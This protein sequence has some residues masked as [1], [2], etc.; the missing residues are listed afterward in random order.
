MMIDYSINKA[1]LSSEEQDT[2]R[3]FDVELQASTVSF[4]QKLREEDMRAVAGILISLK[5][6]TK[7]DGNHI[8]FAF[9]DWMLQ[10]DAWFGKGKGIRWMG[11]EATRKTYRDHLLMLMG[12][13]LVQLQILEHFIHGCCSWLGLKTKN[14]ETLRASDFL[15]TD[16][17]HINKTLGQLK[18]ALEKAGLFDRDFEVRLDEFVKNRNRFVHDYWVQVIK[19]TSSSSPPSFETLTKMEKFLSDLLREAH[20]LE[21]PFRGLFY[22]IDK[23]MA[24]KFNI[25]DDV[26]NRVFMEWSKYEKDF[27]SVANVPGKPAKKSTKA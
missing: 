8:D 25:S 12:A 15:S 7:N 23:E 24:E 17:N 19:D 2:L 13:T 22:S 4:K 14:G 6:R 21:A 9:G 3:K 26:R 1:L 27:L 10:A 18:G 20:D 5:S 11:E 16:P